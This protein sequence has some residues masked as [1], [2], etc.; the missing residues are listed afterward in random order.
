MKKKDDAISDLHALND[1]FQVGGSLLAHLPNL[2]NNVHANKLTVCLQYL[3]IYLP[4]KGERNID[5][6]MNSVS[7]LFR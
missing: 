2:S 3:F 6:F 1:I 4:Q 7:K 5:S